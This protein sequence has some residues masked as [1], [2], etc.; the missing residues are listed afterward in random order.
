MFIFENF[1]GFVVFVKDVLE[2]YLFL[3][4]YKRGYIKEVFLELFKWF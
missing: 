3:K 2:S 1:L 4:E